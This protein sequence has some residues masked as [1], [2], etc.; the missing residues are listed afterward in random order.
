MDGNVTLAPTDLVDILKSRQIKRIQY[1][2]ADHFEPWSLGLN[3]K[4][5]KGVA[6]F[7]E[8]SRASPFG[9]K[10]SLF[11]C[12]YVPYHLD[13]GRANGKSAGDAVIFGSRSA[14][15]ERMG[16]EVIRPL[17]ESDQHEMHLHVHH[18]FWT[19]NDS[20]FDNPVSRWVNAN[21]TAAMD[22]ARLELFFARCKEVIGKE[23][24][25]RFD[26]WAF[27]HGN[28]ALAASDPLICTIENELSMIMQH[29]G[30]GD[31]SFPAGRG[32]C[33][34]KLPAPFTC[35][36][37]DRARAYDDPASDPRPV[38]AGTATL[39]P[40][41]FFIWNSPI[42]AR[43]SSID[44]YSEPNREL[45]KTP[46]R[47]LAEWFKGSVSFGSDLFIKTHAHSMK[48]EYKI[49]E[50]GSPI[51][52]CY[53][54]VVKVFEQLL[55]IC[56]RAGV[57]FQLVTVDEVMAWLHSFD[58]TQPAVAPS[59]KERPGQLSLLER[60]AHVSAI[61]SVQT[62]AAGKKKKREAPATATQKSVEPGKQRARSKKAVL[63]VAADLDHDIASMLRTWVNSDPKRV[64]SAG[65]YYRDLL[66][67]DRV[68]QDYERAVLEYIVS[69]VPVDG[70]SI[71]E[72]GVG[73]GILSL[74]LAAKG[75]EV[76]AFEGDRLRYE[77]LQFLADSF[78][79][80]VP[81]IRSRLR[82]VL[83]WF[84]DAFDQSMVQRDRRNLL[85]TTNIVATA[86]ARRQE[87]I[88]DVARDF[89]DLIIDTTRFGIRRYDAE[90]AERF[91]AEVAVG[92][93]TKSTVWRKEPNE[94]WHFQAT[95]GDAEAPSERPETLTGE[96]TNQVN[97]PHAEGSAVPMDSGSFNTEVL[98][99]QR[100][101]I[102]GEGA[103]YQP[104][105]LYAS[106]L[107]RGV[108]LEAYEAAIASAIA[109]RFDRNTAIVEIGSGYG[110]LALRLAQDGFIVQG[111]E[112]DRRRSAACAWHLQQYLARYP[113]LVGRVDCMP[114]F[115]PDVIPAKLNGKAGKRVCLATNV[116]CTYTATHHDSVLDAMKGFDELIIDL[117][118]FGKSRNTQEERDALRNA[119]AK[120]HFEPV[121]RLFFAAPYEY[122]RFR[123]R[124]TAPKPLADKSP[125]QTAAKAQVVVAAT[126][127]AATP[128]A[129]STDAVFPLTG[130]AGVLYSVYGNRHIDAC[131]VCHGGNTVGLWRMPMTALKEPISLFG[132]YFN[133]V[134][135]L[136][137][138]GVVYC[139]DFCRDCESVFLNP[140]PESQKDQYRRS[141]HYLRTMQS[142]AQWQG[143][144]NA[145][146]R[147]E[148]WIPEGATT[149][150]DAAC[151]IG[152]YLEVARKR[153][154]GRWKRLIG[155]ELSEKYVAHMRTQ[156]LESYAFDIDNDDLGQFVKPG[157]VDF[158]TFC[159]AFEHVERPLDAL[160]KLLVTL[161]PGGRLYFTAQRYGTDVQAAVRPGEPIY[162]GEKVLNEL[163]QR[164]GCQVVNVTTSGMRYYVILEK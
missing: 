68:L 141:D 57:E 121:E 74:L 140:A 145:Y 6:R 37:L 118:R 128:A 107:A 23:I 27:V 131:P 34:P 28:W 49:S 119:M 115:F 42:K 164:L 11:Y 21:S 82:P 63:D 83:G 8:M 30:F 139:F 125:T 36:P 91:N 18:E 51:P 35:L 87:V 134:P 144:E 95:E 16:R 130:Q 103:P 148:K 61:P 152:Q 14:D 25:Q 15:Q 3:E 60:Q 38:E 19:R 93:R 46:D 110:A 70:T 76:I 101:W 78:A 158:V 84:P 126:A 53:P 58:G 33:D 88:L 124:S 159:E 98:A 62:A 40:D 151:G 75:Y 32:Y 155:L 162:I 5:A 72:V 135:T 142:E 114:G 156:D 96:M 47:L 45:F 50:D 129:V 77:G 106:K 143:Y 117:S 86:S 105:D 127:K 54:D 29:G 9:R 92:Y 104:D 123:I 79:E 160:A 100:D 48:W 59:I 26:R 157:S 1:F 65:D 52:H 20:N 2:H 12:P 24:G 71:V 41:R 99:L 163:P 67:G 69:H 132:G 137:V 113:Q 13:A 85:L 122:W 149:L 102:G 120:S 64:A 111:C 136:Q 94:I 22:K 31:F 10:H 43:Y 55:R 138:P 109:E 17:V 80:R 147:F 90:A 56:D 7:G 39:Q 154:P 4:T 108:A 161:R 73:Y 112:G 153:S 116:T 97:Q 89:D 66:K 150:M 81:G 133:Q 44:Y 146:N